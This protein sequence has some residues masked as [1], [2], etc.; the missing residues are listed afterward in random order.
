MAHT[1]LGPSV[2]LELIES[3]QQLGCHLVHDQA[4]AAV[5]IHATGDSPAAV[6]WLAQDPRAVIHEWYGADLIAPGWTREQRHADVTADGIT[7][8]AYET[9]VVRVSA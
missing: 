4:R 9:R 5:S 3:L 6:E 8:R 2:L 7:V 1:N